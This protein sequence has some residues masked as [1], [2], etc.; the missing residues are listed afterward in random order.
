M[1][2]TAT[3][4]FPSATTV[5]DG[6]WVVDS[7][8]VGFPQTEDAIRADLADTREM[9]A[10]HPEGEQA[11]PSKAAVDAAA[12]AFAKAAETSAKAAPKPSHEQ[13]T[14]ADHDDDGAQAEDDGARKADEAKPAEKKKRTAK[15]RIDQIQSR[16]AAFRR[17][18]TE[19]EEAATAAAERRRQA[20][21]RATAAERRVRAIEPDPD[22][23]AKRPRWSQ[24]DAAGK[25][26]E[27]YEEADTAW[28]QQFQAHVRRQAE[29]SVQ[30]SREAT[31]HDMRIADARQRYT[32]FNE[33]V[34]ATQGIPATPFLEHLI[35]EHP[36]GLDVL[37][38]IGKDPETAQVL[39]A[40][41]SPEI[42]QRGVLPLFY[43]A[44]MDQPAVDP[45][46]VLSYLAD[47]PEEAQD[48]MSMTPRLALVALGKLIATVGTGAKTST[49]SPRPTKK[50]PVPFTPVDGGSSMSAGADDPEPGDDRPDD[51]WFE[52]SKRHPAARRTVAP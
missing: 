31:A 21:E 13:A 17:E 1:S 34:K 4:G 16:I 43:Q 44:F 46:P 40:L 36:K 51:E 8:S 22:I 32:D 38:R 20:E 41:T 5:D 27:E 52:W 29:S 2:D 33:T 49:G 26:Y 23:I 24:F 45:T 30:A 11:P 15:D 47:N 25:T 14:D 50:S 3:P 39:S 18:Q 42:D 35:K 7:A 6:D 19:A 48:I 12:D 37:Y 10:V 28:L 9:P